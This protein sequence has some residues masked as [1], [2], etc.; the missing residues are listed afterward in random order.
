M[1]R[2]W[3]DGNLDKIRDKIIGKLEQRTN[4]SK[5]EDSS[6]VQDDLKEAELINGER[7]IFDSEFFNVLKLKCTHKLTELINSPI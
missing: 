3:L 2:R 7:L 4:L 5:R 6:L 1:N